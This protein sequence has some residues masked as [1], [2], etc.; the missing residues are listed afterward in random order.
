M[1]PGFDVISCVLS[2]QVVLN[3]RICGGLRVQSMGEMD[4]GGYCTIRATHA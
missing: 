4:Y 3:L 1:R 2:A